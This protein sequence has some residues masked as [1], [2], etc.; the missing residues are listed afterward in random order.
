MRAQVLGAAARSLTVEMADRWIAFRDLPDAPVAA[1][2][3]IG[4]GWRGGP[5]RTG[6]G[7]A[8]LDGLVGDAA[9]RVRTA[10]GLWTV[11]D[12]VYGVAAHEE[13]P[14]IQLAFNVDERHDA[15]PEIRDLCGV[16]PSIARWRQQT[17]VRLADWTTHTPRTSDP[18]ELDAMLQSEGEAPTIVAAWFELLGLAMPVDREP[19]PMDEAAAARAAL[20]Q[21]AERKRARRHMPAA[22]W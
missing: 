4:L 3:P 22:T 15:W 21:A 13:E 11:G 6:Q 12:L 17:A 1:T 18:L 8:D 10:F 16:G 5:V 2:L 20:A 9:R 7:A 14:A 19:D